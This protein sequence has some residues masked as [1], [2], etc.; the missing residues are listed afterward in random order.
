VKRRKST[1]LAPE[2]WRYSGFE[3]SNQQDPDSPH[4][5]TRPHASCRSKTMASTRPRAP[6]AKERTETMFAT[7]LPTK[8]RS[9]A[10]SGTSKKRG[11]PQTPAPVLTKTDPY[12]HPSDF[13]PVPV[14]LHKLGPRPHQWVV[15]LSRHQAVIQSKE[16]VL[17]ITF[18]HLWNPKMRMLWISKS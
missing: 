15:P 12:A 11:V 4:A 2:N 14:V 6:S 7:A 5:P 3:A 10:M 16:P 18:R 1:A 9:P 13:P 17:G 8:A